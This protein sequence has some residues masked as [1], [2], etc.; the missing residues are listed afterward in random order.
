MAVEKFALVNDQNQQVSLLSIGKNIIGRGN[1]E[2][3][4]VSYVEI[5]SPNSS[6]SRVQANIEICPNGDA[7]ISDCNSTNGT[8]LAVHHEGNSS[9]KEGR[10]TESL[11]ICLKEKYYYQLSD[12][13]RI[14]FGDV[15]RV[16]KRLLI[17]DDKDSHSSEVNA[18]S[19][20]QT[21][22][23]PAEREKEDAPE[24]VPVKNTIRIGDDVPPRGPSSAIISRSVSSGD[25]SS[26]NSM[27]KKAAA[28]HL[29][30]HAE[31]HLPYLAKEEHTT[32]LP[33]SLGRS[34]SLT[35][36]SLWEKESMN[37]KPLSRKRLSDRQEISQKIVHPL[38]SAATSVASNSKKLCLEETRRES[39][40][41]TFLVSACLSGMDASEKE[42][43]KKVLQKFG[44]VV[45]DITKASVLIVRLPAVRTPK[46]IIAVGR[47][48]PVVGIDFFKDV[49]SEED[50]TKRQALCSRENLLHHMVSLSHGKTEYSSALLQKSIA[51]RQHE[52]EESTCCS[53][54]LEGHTFSLLD[55]P[56]K[57]KDVA[58]EV[59]TGCGGKAMGSRSKK[60]SASGADQGTIISINDE[61]S[62]AELYDG[63]L[64]GNWNLLS[65]KRKTNTKK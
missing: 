33:S 46:F 47:G 20:S 25:G 59:I 37:S 64:H 45:E 17:P 29:S 57:V 12:G 21:V 39:K 60:A 53:P 18:S 4:G 34:G 61:S 55:L 11:G 19:E 36:S 54:I 8:F 26:R 48:V 28:H 32:D 56:A 42:E 14:T 51:Q 63:I 50:V 13:C 41:S 5:S 27:E 30:T 49:F 62:V 9:I 22:S 2:L 7:W 10:E 23:F 15:E 31:L 6:V 43:A 16:F 1:V 38:L 52:K 35:A 3:K 24:T 40:K 58:A 44:R 65:K